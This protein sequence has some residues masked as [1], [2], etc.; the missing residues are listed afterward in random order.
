MFFL[1]VGLIL[2]TKIYS[3]RTSLS[4]TF[5]EGTTYYFLQEG[6]YTS[7]EIMEENTKKLNQKAIDYNNDKYYVYVGITKEASLA[8]KI[9][10]L[11]E[12]ENYQIY[13]KEVRL[14]NEEF[15]S[16][17]TQFDLLMNSASTK[18]ELLTIM[19][20]VLANYEEIIIKQ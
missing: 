15:D 12:N 20:V 7:K 16:N 3:A 5:G 18:E 6:V 8:K 17:V 2:G 1:L 11:Y 10:E 19:E 14:S 13:I 9:K 4:T